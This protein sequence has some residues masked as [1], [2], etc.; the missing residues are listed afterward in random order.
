MLVLQ[1]SEGDNNWDLPGGHIHYGE[2]LIDGCK[3]ETKEETNLD[4]SNLE[5]LDKN[6]NV[7]F[8]KAQRPKGSIKLQPEE[9]LKYKWINQV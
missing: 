9:H 6:R 1:R 8:Y 4:I 5:L 3:R 7:T 2:S